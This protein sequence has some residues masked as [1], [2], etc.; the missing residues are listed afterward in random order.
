MLESIRTHQRALQLILLLII[1][2]SFVFF[3]IQSYT[4]FFDKSTDLIKV[5]GKV[6]TVNELDLAT[7]R[8]AEK[9]GGNPTIAANPRFKQSVLNELVQQKLVS[10]ELG[11]LNLQVPDKVLAKQLFLIPEIFALKK[12]DG[13]IDQDKYKQLLSSNQSTVKQFEDSKRDEIKAADLQFSLGIGGN[14][15]S[16]QK[17]ANLISTKFAIEREVQ[18][19]FFSAQDYLSEVKPTDIE[20]KNYYNEHLK[21]F[22]TM[23]TANVEY[24]VLKTSKIDNSNDIANK[25]ANIVFQQPESLNPVA[26]QLNLKIQSAQNVGAQGISE[27][28]KDHPLNQTKLLKAIFVDDVLKDGHNT[29]AVLV[30]PD[31]LVSARVTKYNP[32]GVKSYQDVKSDIIK[33][34]SYHL[35]EDLALKKGREFL[36]EI[37]KNPNFENREKKFGKSVWV[38]RRKPL[39]LHNES[40][41]RVF[42]IKTDHL[43]TI[44]S[45]QIPTVGL[46]IFRINQIR[47]PEDLDSKTKVEQFKQIAALSSQSE[48]AAY[49]SN[50]RGR[51]GLK[52]LN[53]VQ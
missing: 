33:A 31:T 45:A 12:A 34:V 10:F 16:S 24:V 52:L 18:A 4:G 35:A 25:F 42:S 44:T 14:V 5:N 17:L 51:A 20:L 30:A 13:T 8:Q 21:S 41:E 28:P 26:E 39:D 6:I 32:A 7:K 53:P 9:I 29:N 3:G 37:E 47:T 19:I 43:P 38:S 40:Y 27:L 15:I 23:P 22:A 1:F 48:I 36:S 11:A 49:F 46:A 50:I 2:P